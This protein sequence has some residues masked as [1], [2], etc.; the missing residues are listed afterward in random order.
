MGNTVLNRLNEFAEQNG[1][2]IQSVDYRD[3]VF[4]ENVHLNCFYCDRYDS[5][6]RCPPR[7]PKLD[8]KKLISEFENVA[9]VYKRYKITAE[10]K[11]SVRA[12]STNHLHKSLLAM[13]KIIYNSNNSRMISFIGGSCKLCKNGCG[14]T[15]CNNP[16]N[17]RVPIEATGM[18]VEKSAAKYGI[19]IIWPISD[20]MLRIGMILW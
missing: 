7:M 15:R 13:E 14:E 12:D 9:F 8:Y 5:N 6:W 10:N 19:E 1:L 4:E 2:T 11:D 17:S 3:L 20:H 16:Y 18:N